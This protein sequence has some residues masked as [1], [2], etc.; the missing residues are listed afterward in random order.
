[1]D[2]KR[3]PLWDN[4]RFLL[5]V[6][7]VVGHYIDQ[8]NCGPYRSLFFFITIFHM[9]LFLFVSGLFHSNRNILPKMLSYFAIYILLKIII[10]S[11]RRAFGTE[12]DFLVFEELGVPWFMFAL[13]VFLGLTYLLRNINLKFILLFNLILALFSG[14]DQNVADFL[15][16]S[17]LIVY[18]PF[19]LAGVLV[20]R[21]DLENLHEK[22]IVRA[23]SCVVLMICA[24]VCLLFCDRIYF[25]RHLFTGRNP[26][27][28]SVVQYGPLYRLL[29]YAVTSIVGFAVIMITPA[30]SLGPVTAWGSRTL[31]VYFWHQPLLYVLTGLDIHTLICRTSPGKIAWILLS[32][33][34]T[35]LLSFRIFRFPTSQILAAP[36][37]KENS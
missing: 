9:P 23:A 20:G 1:M 31:Q 5:I 16:M 13:A 12:W 28:D 29:C 24:A 10:F 18:Y 34:I 36:Y 32:V 2:K 17:R 25:L 33:A 26:F 3:I 19:Y 4:L 15:V 6:C 8:I 14:F 37:K 30:R 21:Q 11:V 27:A 35:V 7:V 22:R